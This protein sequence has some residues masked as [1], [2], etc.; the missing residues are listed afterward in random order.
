[1]AGRLI[2]APAPTKLTGTA[3]QLGGVTA[4]AAVALR[5]T[6]LFLW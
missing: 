4:L 1:M 6:T 2:D 3:E 5:K